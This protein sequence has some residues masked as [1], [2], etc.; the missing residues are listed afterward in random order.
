MSRTISPSTGRVYG[1]KRV[2]E[3]WDVARS[4]LYAAQLS[5]ATPLRRGPKP[6]VEDEKLLNMI[7]KDL[8]TTPFSG[9]GHKKVHARLKRQG[10]KVGRN[11]VLKIMKI[12]RLMS[13]HRGV[14]KATNP[15]DGKIITDAP[16]VMWGSDGMK[17][18]T[19]DDGWAWV[20]SVTEHW[21]SEC[22]GWH[23]CKTGDRFAAL[24]PVTQAVKKIYGFLNKDVAK[25]LQLRIDNGSQY[26]SDYF[27]QQLA[28][29][30]IKSSFGL[31]RQPET[32]GVSERFNRTLK[33][34]VINGR[35]FQD[36]EELREAVK[37]FAEVY[38]VQWLVA[39]M[40][41]KSPYE[42]RS[43]YNKIKEAA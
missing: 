7:Q 9:E 33:E 12:N 29:W 18:Q 42:A 5:K 4:T 30:G 40:G 41:Y 22:L 8:S 26:T 3:V 43:S 27:L 1:L 6:I 11:R 19:A 23:V 25:G 16:G 37:L 14:Y 10:V 39:K 28:Y 36:I 13:P 21:N 34:Q 20:F 32:N 31:I 24:E 38:N 15:H 2:C 17:V 35:V